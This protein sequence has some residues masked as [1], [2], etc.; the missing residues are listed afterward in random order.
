MAQFHPAVER[1]T[2]SRASRAASYALPI[3]AFFVWASCAPREPSFVPGVSDAPT[4]GG[5][6]SASSASA[7]P[8][9]WEHLNRVDKLEVLT[10]SFPSRGHG[11]G[12]WDAELRGN[13]GSGAAL[14]AL[15]RGAQMPVGTLLVQRHQQRQVEAEL[16]SFVME[17]R[18]AGYFPA[19]GDWEYLV[20]ARDGRIEARGKLAT[21]ARCHAEAPVDFVF[22][23]TPPGGAP[24]R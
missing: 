10:P 18:A 11:T 17:K 24:N 9:R 6:T 21:C 19:G 5:P 1:P 23:R 22:P 20:V 4:T 7:Q 15:V 12:D 3:A 16:G 2:G 14:D 13:V 8:Q